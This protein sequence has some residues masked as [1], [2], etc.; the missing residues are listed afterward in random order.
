[1]FI[2]Q[3]STYQGYFDSVDRFCKPHVEALI[4][5]QAKFVWDRNI[6]DAIKL[7]DREMAR[8]V[9]EA[10]ANDLPAENLEKIRNWSE[11]HY[12]KSVERDKFYKDLPSK[13]GGNLNLACAQRLGEMTALNMR[14]ER[15]APEAWQYLQ[16]F[17]GTT[18]Q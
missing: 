1:M 11:T 18:K 7:R 8:T 9:D 13:F 16:E 6:E 17:G 15:V 10:V 3:V 14:L 4:L 2:M 5:K 12:R